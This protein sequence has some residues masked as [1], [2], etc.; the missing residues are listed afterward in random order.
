MP[1]GKFP[2]SG[3]RARFAF[4]LVELLVVIAIIGVLVSLL[5]PAVQAAREAARRMQCSNNLKQQALA[6]HT[7]HDSKNR[8]PAGLTIGKTWYSTVFRENP[9]GGTLP[10]SSYPVEGPF[11]SWAWKILPY[12]EN[13]NIS[14]PV[15]MTL[16]SAVWPWWYTVPGQPRNVI[17]NKVAILGC[18]SDIRGLLLHIDDPGNPNFTGVF[19]TSYLGVSGYCGVKES[20]NGSVTQVNGAWVGPAGGQNGLV[21]V[22]SQC[23]FASITDGSS[24]TLLIGERPSS[25]D[26]YYGW[27]FAGSGDFPYF[28]S[29]DVVLGVHEPVPGQSTPDFFRKGTVIDPNSLHR[30]HF[31]SLHPGG[32]QWA[33]GDGSIRFISYDAGGPQRLPPLQPSVITAMS[34][35]NGAETFQLP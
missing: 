20:G 10:G 28:G 32:G 8:F 19:L 7:F 5:L 1:I 16:G 25:N 34:T 21:Y 14:D 4:T 9:P 22:N 27:C 15:D 33:L 31:W 18:P 35:R 11:Y 12:I 6:F 13:G 24:N 17:S 26:E 29:T 23:T 30:Y 3:K 2:R